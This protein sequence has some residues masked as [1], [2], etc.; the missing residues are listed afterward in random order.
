MQQLPGNQ[1]V[2]LCIGRHTIH[3]KILEQSRETSRPDLLQA[4]DRLVPLAVTRDSAL[5]KERLIQ[6]R[7]VLAGAAG[8]EMLQQKTVG[9]QSPADRGQGPRLHPTMQLDP[10][11]AEAS[12]GDSTSHTTPA[13]TG[14][15][16][17]AA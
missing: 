4:R 1:G 3:M 17:V 11:E 9:N 14:V 16:S 5:A 6:C 2:E 8:R 10:C 15:Q 7:K 13:K 12:R